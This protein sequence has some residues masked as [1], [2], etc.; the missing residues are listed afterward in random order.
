MKGKYSGILLLLLAFGCSK[1]AS[2][3]SERP[4]AVVI[5]RNLS[6]QRIRSFAEDGQ[7][8]IWIGTF[9][10]L[11]RFAAGEYIQYFQTED[12][13]GLPD[14]EIYT[15]Y[16]DRRGRLW[17]TTTNGICYY[18]DKGRFHQ[19][20][21]GVKNLVYHVAETDDGRL[22]F[23][24]R[25]QVM[26]FLPQEDSIRVNVQ[27]SPIQGS[28]CQLFLP[29]KDKLLVL[30][31]DKMR[32]YNTG[33][34]S[35]I[36]EEVPARPSGTWATA[37]DGK[38]WCSGNEG[39]FLL[40]PLT[41]SV[42]EVPKALRSARELDRQ[43]RAILPY[44]RQYTIFV[45]S[46]GELLVYDGYTETLLRTADEKFPFTLPEKSVSGIFKDRN[47]NLWLGQ[48]NYGYSVLY[49]KRGGFNTN[50]IL[51]SRIKGH[52]VQSL[53]KDKLGKLWIATDEMKLYVYDQ[54][55]LVET[56]LLKALGADAAQARGF[57][58]VYAD[59]DGSLW[60]SV[61]GAG[62]YRFSYRDGQLKKTGHW[63]YNT[64]LS[65]EDDGK[66]HVWF[67]GF[68]PQ[69]FCVDKQSGELRE[70]RLF[71]D[72]YSH[73]SA[74]IM[75]EE[76]LLAGAFPYDIRKIDPETFQ[77]QPFVPENIFR[78]VVNKSEYIPTCFFRDS[79]G[80]LWIGTNSNGLLCW[81]P[82]SRE[83]RKVEGAPCED[84]AAVQEDSQGNIWVSTQY[85]LGKYSKAEKS[86][87]NYTEPDKIGG[88]QFSDRAAAILPDGMLVFG[89]LHGLTV[90]NPVT[91]SRKREVP[92]S[93]EY[94]KVHNTLVDPGPGA[95][96]DK[97]L[98]LRP[99]VV[100]DHTQK[101][102]SIA[103]ACLD[104]SNNEKANYSYKMD[105][106][107]KYWVEAGD[108]HEAYYSNLGPGRYTFRVRI[109]SNTIADKEIA[110]PVRVK[111][112]PLASPLAIA[113]YVLLA[114]LLFSG[115]FLLWFRSRKERQAARQAQQEK[116]E[117]Q[118]INRTN[119][120]FFANVAHEFRTP[121]TLIS[122]PVALLSGSPTA[123]A[124]DKRML[125]TVQK[126]VD[127]LL[128]L[129]N[130][131]LDMGK[132][133]TDS[134]PLQVSWQDIV[135]LAKEQNELFLP[136]AR[137]KH[138]NFE[139]YCHENS[140]FMWL[141]ADKITKIMGNLL[142]NA[143]KFTPEGGTVRVMLDV[144]SREHAE[145]TFP[146]TE[147]DTQ[148]NYLR[149]IVSDTGPG[150]PEALTEK[151]FE[152]YYQVEGTSGGTYN[153]GTGIGLYFSRALVSLHHG[154]IHADNRETGT[155]AVFTFIL[156]T[157]EDAY[158]PSEKDNNKFVQERSK[159]P[160][161]EPLPEPG[162][163][164]STGK[165]ILVVDDDI[166][167]TQYLKDILSAEYEVSCKFNA[168]TAL[169]ALR[170]KP[171]DLV[172][173]DVSMPG[174][175]GYALCKDIKEDAQLCHIPVILVTAKVTVENQI[176]GLDMGADAY[177][178]KPFDPYYLRSLIRSQLENRDR[179]QRLVRAATSTEAI[180]PSASLS[181]QDSDF[182]DRLYKLM[183]SE[184][185]NPELDVEKMAST[186]CISRSKLFYK[187]KGLTGQTPIDFFKQYKLNRA[188]QLL[189]DG[190]YT[191]AQVS[192]LTGFSSPSKFSTLFK[193]QFGVPPSQARKQ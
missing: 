144:I 46:D 65:Y 13:T 5:S 130:Q 4:G 165:G 168:E 124:E 186:L 85:G 7:G 139:F 88:N 26:E 30:T 61:M 146:L 137:S 134:L 161:E 115:L 48:G 155:G 122:G 68:Y 82:S 43:A 152:R 145:R 8:H 12:G 189:Q 74:L 34:F 52:M 121:L 23:C 149:V 32:L 178:T 14:N 104:Y 59:R 19:P 180:A 151:I 108:A 20:R 141:D 174:K 162:R 183:E 159:A 40:D 157:G 166:E 70:L 105:G 179:M 128:T 72:G 192:D 79:E 138:I 44:D 116:Q 42:G 91:V 28:S 125:R 160:A 101:G 64:I 143:F 95:A 147:A 129:V 109:G 89:G 78:A 175:D 25:M 57:F 10:G 193:K 148:E 27:F 90:V 3:P 75:T 22:F 150:I 102:F 123:S 50:D 67:G 16:C 63:P 47:G 97:N 24:D 93:F 87:T 76:G 35:L 98:S 170:N 77:V 164:A 163:V 84:I 56:D 118:R 38:I 184:L 51:T 156:P 15:L 132:L 140:Y 49:N 114:A 83:L 154:Y 185:T 53:T 36:R 41:G 103:Y 153:Y 119:T 96:I 126:N 182:L 60:I 136:R 176:Q 71:P 112:A 181:K 55:T 127:R 171:A 177:V 169:E 29:D 190:Q 86:F 173:S 31:S 187:I 33:D 92:L 158:A 172:I 62:V 21:G 133:E 142:S 120:S 6:N 69:V 45:S 106:V 1:N 188:A 107:D 11:N 37:S 117:Q 111:A 54:K 80:L 81:N 39:L 110:L 17:T 113:L 135:P 94:L 18:T 2:V 66:G 9:R 131:L 167:V 191:I 100:L 73:V 99:E 58:Q